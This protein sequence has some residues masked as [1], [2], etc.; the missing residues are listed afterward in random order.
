MAEVSPQI[1]THVVDPVCGMRVDPATSKRFFEYKGTTYYFCGARCLERFTNDP[2]SFLAKKKLEAA[3]RE[4]ERSA[5]AADAAS[6]HLP[7]AS[8]G[9]AGPSGVVSEVRHGA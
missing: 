1:S 6:V 4:I 5:P 2:E 3:P 8:R 7:D 9:A